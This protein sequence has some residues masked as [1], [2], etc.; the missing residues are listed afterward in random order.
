MTRSQ[1][2]TQQSEV[3]LM[4]ASKNVL[5]LPRLRAWQKLKE[6]IEHAG[7]HVIE[8][9]GEMGSA[10]NRDPMFVRDPGIIITDTAMANPCY[11]LP[12]HDATEGHHT[13]N[14]LLAKALWKEGKAICKTLEANK[15]WGGATAISRIENVLGTSEGGNAVCDPKHKMLFMGVSNVECFHDCGRDASDDQKT[16]YKASL[17]RAISEVQEKLNRPEAALKDG[18][19]YTVTELEIRDEYCKDFYHLDGVLG[20]L[21]TGHA[22]VFKEALTSAS[23]LM[24][25]RALGRNNIIGISQQD[26]Q[27]G[28]T[29][30][31][32]VGD[33]IVTPFASD[34]LRKTFAELGYKTIAPTDVGLKAGSWMFNEGGAV[35]CATLKITPDHGYPLE[36][37][38]SKGAA[39]GLG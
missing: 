28:A 25:E 35:R 26:A 7:G 4:R 12:V 14:D 30:F 27:Q 39:A 33:T 34:T 11:I 29:N 3:F 10:L 8:A 32:T 9:K 19:H 24:L 20:I 36:R 1:E 23:L 5:S 13:K 17:R 6:A 16:R 22:V 15:Q 31:I 38:L 2:S 18:S 21:P 37:A